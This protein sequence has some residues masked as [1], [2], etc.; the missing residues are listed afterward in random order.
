MSVSVQTQGLSLD[1]LTATGDF[2]PIDRG[3]LDLGM[4]AQLLSSA[5]VLQTPQGDD[6]CPPM[7]LIAGPFGSFS[8]QGDAGTLYCEQAEQ[9]VDAMT[10]AKLALGQISIASLR[11][12]GDHAPSSGRSAA[13]PKPKAKTK[14]AAA[15][16]KPAASMSQGGPVHPSVHPPGK[17]RRIMT[18]RQ[19]G[20]WVFG[21]LAI[22]LMGGIGASAMASGLET[23]NQDDVYAGLLMLALGLV[24]GGLIIYA[25]MRRRPYV[26][27]NGAIIWGVGM[28]MALGSDSMD[29][30]DS[31][32]GGGD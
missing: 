28:G 26:D 25:S 21:G 16:V 19:Y 13:K 5:S 3:D 1:L 17:P 10:G 11:Q 29:G 31:G 27:D 15:K 20:A 23:G 9:A 2:D 18:W 24:I 6:V 7:V 14:Q 30:G 8:F 32:G 22:V 12:R 4:V